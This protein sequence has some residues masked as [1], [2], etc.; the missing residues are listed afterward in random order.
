MV[1]GAVAPPKLELANEDLIKAHVHAVW[2]AATGQSLGSSLRDILD[3]TGEEPTLEPLPSVQAAFQSD[4]AANEAMARSKRILATIEDELQVADWYSDGW[5]E[6][7]L[8]KAVLSFEQALERWRALYRAAANQRETQ[9]KIIID[10]SRSADD[11]K[12]AKRLRREAEAQLE[13]LLETK[14]YRDSD[15]YSYRYF[16]SEGFLPGYNFPRLPLSAFIPGKKGR[17]DDFLSRPRFLAISEFGPRSIVYHEGS[18]F[19][20]NKVIMP[21]GDD[22]VLTRSAK[23]CP[24]CG[25]LHP[26]VDGEGLDL[27]EYCRRPLQQPLR[28]L[29]RLQNVA[30]RRRDRINSD[31]EERLRL[32]YELKTTVR[33]PVRGGKP[34]LRTATIEHPTEGVMARLSYGHAATIWRI[35]LGWA[36]RRN[37]NQLGFVLDTER[38]YWARN[39]QAVEEDPADPMSANTTR[40]IPYVE[41]RRNCLLIEPEESLNEKQMASLQGALKQAIQ[42]IYQ[43]EDNEL[44]SEPLPTRDR[45]RVLL[46]YEAAEGGAGV[47]RHL[48]SDP[49]A[50]SAVV[51]QALDLCHFDPETGEDRRRAPRA[52]EDCEA[53][54]YD[55]LMTYGNQRDHSLLDRME[56]R[57]ILMECKHCRVLASPV[58]LPRAEHLQQLLNQAG[59]EL[60]KRW[61]Q[62]L[63]K[64]DFHLPS[65]AQ[66]FLEKCKTRPDFIYDDHLA[67]IY[68]DG[69]IHDFSDRAKRDVEQTECLEDLGYTV[70]RFGHQDDWQKLVSKF[71]H[72]FGVKKDN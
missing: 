27:C 22:E 50:F 62:F 54:C 70:I 13:L 57:D 30:T 18:R 43:L 47:L 67:I 68:V 12:Q 59:S 2:L 26:I 45:R 3:V 5:L 38:G 69:P 58:A 10:A 24:D 17:K 8:G 21:V 33:F 40:V 48:I 11:K 51:S 1:A 49:D 39:E 64:H 7:V 37:Q 20:I 34:S 4:K 9:H 14:I 65:K 63:E 72:V 66:V 71:A 31:E 28:Q 42:T 52:T 53:A 32:G 56:I 44:A 6:E 36:R 16:A 15:F 19:I 46:I 29:F 55:C 41:D 60:E 61:L 23:L 35:N 25:Y